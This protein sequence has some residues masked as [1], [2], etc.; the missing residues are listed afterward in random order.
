MG[1]LDKISAVMPVSVHN[2]LRP[3]VEDTTLRV[4]RKKLLRFYS[5][6]ISDGDLVFDVG[7]HYGTLTG[8]F[9]ELGAK[10]VC[11]EPQP[12]CFNA[13]CKK[14]GN[15]DRAVIVN[16]GLDR[17][18]GTLT[19]HI[20]DKRPG[21]TTFSDKWQTLDILNGQKWS[22]KK[23]VEVTTLDSIIQAYGTPKFCKIDVEGFENNVL[24][25]L[26]SNIDCISFEFSTQFLEDATDAIKY[27]STIC[28][29]ILNLSLWHNFTLE[30]EEWIPLEQLDEALRGF[31]GIGDIY[32][33]MKP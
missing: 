30:Y 14:Y 8:I 24:H 3:I 11:I 6:F 10:V 12:S 15:N 16:K 28:D 7:A 25:G 2:I 18:D 31:D 23:E 33:K 1:I 5:E 17:A 4:R 32:V 20:S 26:S 21:T 9:I 13:L 29:I 27:L 22:T 19:L